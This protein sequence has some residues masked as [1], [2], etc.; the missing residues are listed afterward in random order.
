MSLAKRRIG[1]YL[2]R[3]CHHLA[4]R[5][6]N[7]AKRLRDWGTNGHANCRQCGQRVHLQ[8]ID[9]TGLCI[10]CWPDN[11]DWLPDPEMVARSERAI[12]A[13]RSQPIQDVIDELT[14]D[15]K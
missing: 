5:L 1:T 3:L 8:N 14:R 12:E 9:N 15:D 4:H 13:G 7:L 2:A 11:D 10:D 6:T